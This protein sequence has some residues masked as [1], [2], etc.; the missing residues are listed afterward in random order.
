MNNLSNL[1]QTPGLSR[2]LAYGDYIRSRHRNRRNFSILGSS[3]RF[4]RSYN[5]YDVNEYLEGNNRNFSILDEDYVEEYIHDDDEIY[6][7]LK[8][9]KRGLELGQLSRVSFIDIEFDPF[10]CSICFDEDKDK[11]AVSRRLVC[12]HKFHIECIETWL[13]ENTSCPICR[14]DLNNNLNNN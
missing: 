3:V 10:F 4:T 9:L 13:S 7:E 11:V 1:P 2:R 14:Y 12:Q 6:S 8:R 5:Q